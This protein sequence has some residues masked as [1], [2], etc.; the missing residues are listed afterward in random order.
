MSDTTVSPESDVVAG[1]ALELER[2]AMHL[3][4]LAGLMADIAFLQGSTTYGWLW[5]AGP[6]FGLTD[7]LRNDLK[8]T[9]EAF[10][11]D[12]AEVNDLVVS[13]LAGPAEAG[14]YA[15]PRRTLRR[16]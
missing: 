2:V 3:A 12:M 16:T 13:Q 8:A 5:P 6:R 10:S 11:R 1:I 9:L 4:T 7:D 14:H 15:G